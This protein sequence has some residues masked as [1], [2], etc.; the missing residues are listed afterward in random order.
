MVCLRK[1]SCIVLPVA[2]GHVGPTLH[3]RNSM[4]VVGNGYRY[5]CIVGLRWLS[6]DAGSYC[7]AAVSWER[8][9]DGQK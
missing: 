5:S 8:F 4:I 2:D 9:R 1:C 3:T 6:I 7:T